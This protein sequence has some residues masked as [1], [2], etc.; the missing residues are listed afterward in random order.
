MSS[1]IKVNDE[2]S[3]TVEIP[4]EPPMERGI[5]TCKST[6]NEIKD[7]EPFKNASN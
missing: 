4:N 2:D 1:Q 5:R 3:H 6:T 7:D